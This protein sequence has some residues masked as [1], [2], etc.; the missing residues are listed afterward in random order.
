VEW[1]DK[2]LDAVG[3]AEGSSRVLNF[4]ESDGLSRVRVRHVSLI[5]FAPESGPPEWQKEVVRLNEAEGF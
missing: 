5:S 1:V 3:D 4:V 2:P